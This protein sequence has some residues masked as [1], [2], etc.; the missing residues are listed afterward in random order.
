LRGEQRPRAPAPRGCPHAPHCVP[1]PLRGRPYGEQLSLKKRALADAIGAYRS[2]ATTAV[3]EVVGSRDLFGYR[4]VAKLVVR[5]AP[6]GR[7][8]AGVYE[9]GSHR[10]ADAD[11]CEVHHP[12]VNEVIA[13]TLRA[14]STLDVPVYDDRDGSGELRYLVVRA[15]ARRRRAWLTPSLAGIFLNLNADPGN[16]ILGPRFTTLRPPAEL[17]ERFGFA[18]VQASPGA[19]LQV[20]PWTARRIYE[21]TLEWSGLAEGEVAVDL[22]CGVG[23]LALHLATRAARVVGV[24]E[25]PSAITDARANARR[26]GIGNTRFVEGR[27]EDALPEL[28][29]D[30][31][32]PAVVTLN[33]PRK[34]AEPRLL[35]A[36]AAAAPRRILYV[37]CDPR[38]LARDLDRLAARGFAT[39]RV[40]PFDMMPQTEHVETV[41][42]VDRSS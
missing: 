20:N 17:V 30:G 29:A 21:T 8:R 6:S 35:D 19:F 37:S 12:V 41:A 24:E 2:L 4:T 31:L 39:V 28:V 5:R 40:A 34:G 16:V 1:C 10:L 33:P 15:S 7:L 36:I 13:A 42:V 32:R 11:A 38:S 3:D 18:E 27:A 14:A 9:P 26:N 22:Y 25:V 23:A